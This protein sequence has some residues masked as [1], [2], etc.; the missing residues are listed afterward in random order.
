MDEQDH[1]ASKRLVRERLGR[2]AESRPPE[3]EAL[4]ADIYHPDAAWR[5]SHPLNEMAG[6]SAIA[7]RVWRPLLEAFPD[8]ERRETILI[9]GVSAV[10]GAAMVASVGHYCGTFA[11]SWLDIPATGLTAY[12]RFGEVHRVEAGRIVETTAIWDL[13]DLMRQAGV[14]PVAPSLGI[15]EQWPAPFTGDGIVLG[16]SDP[17]LS[18]ASLE[19]TLAM[20]ATLGAYDD[21]AR[22]GREGLLAMPQ[23]EHWHPRMMWYGPAGIGTARGLAGF[24]DCHQL[25]FRLGFP[26]RRGGNHYIQIGDGAYSATGGWPSVLAKHTGGGFMAL[27]PTGRDVEMRVM[28]FYL[29][30]EGLIRENWV[31]LDIIHL[32]LQMDVDVFARMRQLVRRGG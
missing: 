24:V 28:D 8:L 14:W 26:N 3:A 16:E 5:G 7:A 21:E 19:Q 25:P 22:A 4:L 10:S 11:H 27:S 6:V 15:E 1:S 12:L 9:G 23:R 18:A 13:L 20:Q 17:A 30:H 2:V 31:P 32:L 29:H